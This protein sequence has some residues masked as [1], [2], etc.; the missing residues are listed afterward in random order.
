MATTYELSYFE[1][2]TGLTNTS[3]VYGFDA[4]TEGDVRIIGY[5]GTAQTDLSGLISSVNTATKT[6]TLSSA[7]TGYDKIR[8]YR[9]TTVLPLVDFTSGAVLSEDALNTA[10]RH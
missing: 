1:T 9:S 6:M 5:I 10:Y 2:T 3:F 4:L 8:I 7:P